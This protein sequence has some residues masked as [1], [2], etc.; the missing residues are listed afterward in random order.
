MFFFTEND[1]W[2][3]KTEIHNE[4]HKYFAQ[5]LKTSVPQKS[6]NSKVYQIVSL[7]GFIWYV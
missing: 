1:Q 3:F 5:L 2:S 6:Y 4:T 7:N